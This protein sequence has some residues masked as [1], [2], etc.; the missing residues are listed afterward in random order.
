MT[1]TM[2]ADII[3]YLGKYEKGVLCLVNLGYE[4]S[5]YDA[6]FYYTN[7]MIAL[8]ISEELENTLQSPIEF[9][10]GYRELVIT[11]LK[12]VVPYD[13]IINRL[14]DVDFATLMTPPN[15]DITLGEEID[16]DDIFTEDDLEDLEDENE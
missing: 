2:T 16:E 10:S 14:D 12:K 15:E 13:E 6:S 5:F 4:G 11:I 1:N 9:W 3:E 7:E 8:T